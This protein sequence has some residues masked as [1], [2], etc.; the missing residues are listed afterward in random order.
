MNQTITTVSDFCIGG[1]D[2]VEVLDCESS[3][4]VL[5]S[6]IAI[7][8]AGCGIIVISVVTVIIVL[9]IRNRR[10]YGKYQKLIV[11]SETGDAFNTANDDDE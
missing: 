8:S 11:A 7:I 3:V 6:L 9:V 2:S 1:K 4:A 5:T 10:L